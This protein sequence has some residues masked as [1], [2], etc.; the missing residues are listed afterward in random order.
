MTNACKM[1]FFPIFWEKIACN[2]CEGKPVVGKLR[3]MQ[4]LY[5]KLDFGA[6][7][8]RCF[9]RLNFDPK[10]LSGIF[11]RIHPHISELTKFLFN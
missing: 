5:H 11:W 4:R 7:F 9:A 6:D 8:P 10:Y 2:L 3:R 1:T